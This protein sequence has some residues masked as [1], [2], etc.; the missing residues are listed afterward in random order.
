MSSTT[1]T[2][3]VCCDE[4]SVRRRRPIECPHCRFV[5]CVACYRQYILSSVTEPSCMSCRVQ[6][7]YEFLIEHLPTTFWNREYK[8]FR[9]N[10]LLAREESLLPETQDIVIKIHKKDN[11]YRFIDTYRARISR[12]QR[13]LS[14]MMYQWRQMCM[15]IDR[16]RNGR[17]AVEAAD[18]LFEHFDD[19]YIPL[20]NDQQ[21]PVGLTNRE[22]VRRSPTIT[23]TTWIFACPKESCR[24]MIRDNH[25]CPLCL[26]EA[27]SQCLKEKAN[28]DHEC[29]TEDV[30]T[31]TLLRQNTKSC[32]KCSMSIFKVSGCDQM[33]CTQCHTPFSWRTGEIIDQRVHNPHYYEW[34]QRG[35]QTA[36]RNPMDIPCGGMPELLELDPLFTKKEYRDWMYRMHRSVLH[37]ENVTIPRSETQRDIHNNERSMRIQYLMNQMTRNQW[38]DELYRTEKVRQKHNQYIQ[39]MQTFVAVATDWLRRM[40]VEQP[41]EQELT[42]SIREICRFFEYI[43]N[44]VGRMNQR[45]KSSLQGLPENLVMTIG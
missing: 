28:D 38:K 3:V 29:L 11:Y 26:T 9:K 16:E 39:I 41:S 10:M 44:Q 8:E 42:D 21:E 22:V 6:M 34:L 1:T 18:H 14:A 33:W 36:A 40:L 45:Y 25:R 15:A 30:E 24:G 31:A 35:G 27:C 19:L 4:F 7:G 20:L 23:T 37:V 12:M 13:R 17:P 43:Q 32:P 2:C 5:C